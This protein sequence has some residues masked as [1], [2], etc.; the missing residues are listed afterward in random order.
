MNQFQLLC[1]RAMLLSFAFLFL[2]VSFST[3]RAAGEVDPTFNA[4]VQ[5]TTQGYVLTVV[6]QP[7]GKLLVGGNFSIAGNSARNSVARFNND[8]TVDLTFNPPDF[9]RQIS[10][11]GVVLGGINIYAVALQADG[12]VL[13]GGDFYQVGTQVRLGLARLNAD[14]SLDNSFNP[15][16]SGSGATYIYD[17]KIQT[18]NQI[19]I[20]GNI[21]LFRANINGSRDT[22]FNAFGGII[23]SFVIQ[24]DGKIVYGTSDNFQNNVRRVNSDGTVDNSFLDSTYTANGTSNVF[25][26]KLA[27]QTDG[28]VLVGGQFNIS[29][30][31][32]RNI[33]RLNTNGVIDPSFNVSGTGTYGGNGGLVRNL[34]VLTDGKIIIGGDFG[35]YNN[36]FRVK[37][38]RLNSD[39]TLDNN[40]SIIILE[41][42]R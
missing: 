15:I 6:Q 24:P 25:I 21:G 35:G 30:S 20:S 38:A 14:G 7:D 1:K 29:G 5:D 28:K 32:L 16:T 18:D 27:L 33:I 39:G 4:A 37:T 31:S 17:I 36:T 8:G 19:L 23:R 10:G 2:T 22:S 42:F 3:V 13:V 41:I 40:L 9:Y 34:A 11:G 12:K 26:F